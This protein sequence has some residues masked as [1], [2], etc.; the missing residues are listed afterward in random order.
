[1]HMTISV[2]LMGGDHA[3]EAV[4][5]GVSLALG[6]TDPSVRFLLFGTKEAL[7]AASSALSGPEASRI[8]YVE[9]AEVIDCEEAPTTAIRKKKDSSLVKA[10]ESVAAGNADCV[11]SAGNTGA[12]LA[13][14]TLIIKRIK[15]VKRPALVTALPTVQGKYAVLLDSG[16]NTDC[17]PEYLNQFGIMG[18]EYAKANLDIADPRVALLNNGA[19]KAKGNELTK[20]AY[21]LLEASESVRFCGNCEARDVLSGDY[22]VIVA[23]GFDGNVLLKGIEGTAMALFKM[24]KDELYSS[25][26]SKIGALLAKPAFRALKH[27][28]DYSEVGGAVLLGVNGGVVKAHG[29]SNAK[30][31]M[32]AIL[33]A[34]KLIN[35]GMIGTITDY[36]ASQQPENE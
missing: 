9:T 20:Q 34:E 25:L 19:E 2:D 32:N 33:Q 36:F 15:G 35:S 12:L 4:I 31:F 24:L 28:M 8:G 17:K 23:D 3:P 7:D 1:M 16:A 21:L 5:S 27:K 26:R 6:K 10:V 14:A 30:A 22:D 29:S 18:A 13:A 11:V